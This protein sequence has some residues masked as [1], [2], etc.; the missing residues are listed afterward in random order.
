M[1]GWG[2]AKA[3]GPEVW[4]TLFPV[5]AGQKQSPIDIKKTSCNTDAALT[6]VRVSYSDIRISELSNS[7]YSWKAQ[8]GSGTS[9]LRGGPLGDD[10]YVLEQFH[11][12]WGKT[13][14]TG[15]EHTVDGTRYAAE[16]HL[17]HWNKS[18]F[19]SFAQAAAAE[20]GLAVLGIFLTVGAHHEEMAKVCNLLPFISHKGQAITMTDV[21]HPE[22]FLPKNGTYWT[23]GGSLT[24]PPCYES[25]TWI[26]FEQPIQVSEAQLQAFRS[27]KSFHPCESCPQDELAGELVENYRP[28]CPLCDREVR[29]FND[30]GEEE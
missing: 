28:P 12:H 10:E 7:G 8:V 22:A 25:V 19:P 24:T 26:V 6:K 11:S 17:V 15:S 3:N 13:N 23:Y 1:F 29:K 4:P 9:S 2:Y 27:M 30:K 5:A 16:L 14:D 20:G 18:K 21:V